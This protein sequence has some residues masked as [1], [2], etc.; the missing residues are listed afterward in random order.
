MFAHL[1]KERKTHGVISGRVHT[2]VPYMQTKNGHW[3]QFLCRA[4]GLDQLPRRT[5]EQFKVIKYFDLN[6]HRYACMQ[7]CLHSSSVNTCTLTSMTK[8][9]DRG[10][11]KTCGRPSMLCCAIFHWNIHRLLRI[12]RDLQCAQHGGNYRPVRVTH[13]FSIFNP[14]CL[15][16]KL[17]EIKVKSWIWRCVTM[18]RFKSA[19]SSTWVHN[20]SSFHS[21][22]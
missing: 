16:N 14:V 8:E 1:T 15:V 19:R 2:L 21:D 20:D 10:V 17:P 7:D 6:V 5:T 18:F 11:I 4:W 13:I 12:L 3:S 22:M 9:M